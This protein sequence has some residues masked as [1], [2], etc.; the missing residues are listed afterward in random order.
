MRNPHRR[1]NA[2][3]NVAIGAGV[4]AFLVLIVWGISFEMGR[5]HGTP[6]PVTFEI[7]EKKRDWFGGNKD[8]QAYVVKTDDG[9]TYQ[10]ANNPFKPAFDW[11]GRPKAYRT[12][13]VGET[14]KCE[15]RGKE[16]KKLHK[17]RK[18]RNCHKVEA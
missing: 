15:A 14:W 18:V 1:N 3:T 9:K 6:K 5:N 13:N 11:Q 16:I 12:M 2:F 17:W 8:E 10:V 4:I 7:K